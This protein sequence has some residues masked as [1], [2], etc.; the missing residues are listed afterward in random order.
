MK[1]RMDK[2]WDNESNAWALIYNQCSPKLKNKLKGTDGYNGAK[3]TNN[4]AKLLAMIQGDGC[5]FDILNNK[6][7]TIVA[8]IKNLFFSFQKGD[9]ANADYHKEFMAMMEVVEEYRGA[10]SLINFPNLLKQ[11]LK[12]KELNLSTTTTEELK[13][14]KKTVWEKFLAALMLN[15]ANGT[16]YNNLKRSMKEIF[17]MGT[18]TYPKSPEAV[19]LILNAYHPPMGWGKRRQDAGAGTKQGAMFAQTEGDNSWKTRVKC[20]NCGKKGHI[21][22]ECPERKQARNQEHIHT[23]IQEGG[24]NEDDIDKGEN[25]FVQKRE[26]GVVNKNWLLLDSQSMVDQ[27]TNPVLLKSIRKVASAVTVHCN[28]GST[29]T[30]LEGDLGNVTVKHNLHSIANVVSLHETKQRHRVTYNSWDQGGVLQVHTDGR[31]VKVK[32]SSRRLHY[33]DVSDPSSNVELMLVNT[34]RENFKGYTRQDVERAREARRI[35]RMIAN[36]TKREFA[37]MVR[38][39]LLTNCPITVRDVDNAN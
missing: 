36:P 6:Y 30:N 5:Q 22:R 4:V 39:K 8:A 7:M 31:I 21:A 27:V 28:A 11:E 13:E 20:H 37:G 14:G 25:I 35:Q 15:G 33:H 38:E 18:S 24:C 23:N 29:S 34:V 10:G 1:S 26:K 32:P 17:A 3:S 12:A 9:Q 2:Y 16:I 19:L